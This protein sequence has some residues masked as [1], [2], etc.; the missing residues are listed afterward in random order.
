MK[1]KL[2]MLMIVLFALATE[3][4]A[5]VE[6]ITMELYDDLPVTTRIETAVNSLVKANVLEAKPVTSQNTILFYKGIK[7]LFSFVPVSKEKYKVDVPKDVTW[8][9]N[10][11]YTVNLQ[12][13]RVAFSVTINVKNFPDNNFRQYVIDN[14]D[15]TQDGILK[16]S[17]AEAVE[18]IDVRRKAVK[19][20]VGIRYFTNLL[21]LYCQN[22]FEVA[23]TDNNLTELDLSYNT[24]LTYLGCGQNWNLTKLNFANCKDLENLYC[25]NCKLTTLNV[26]GFTKLW[27]IYCVGNQ[28]ETLDVT[29]AE[30][31][32]TLECQNNR[33]TNLIVAK[34]EPDNTLL[35]IDCN[36]NQLTTVDVTNN[37][38][39]QYLCCYG[40]LIRG[41][42]METLV[43]SLPDRNSYDYQGDVQF[44]WI[45]NDQNSCTKQQ[46]AAAN[47]KNWKITNTQGIQYPGVEEEGTPRCATPT[48]SMVNGKLKF[49]C[50]TQGVTYNYTI[51]ES[52]V[53][54]GNTSEVSLP[55]TT[56]FTVYVYATKEGYEKS[57][58]AFKDIVLSVGMKG[59][60]DDNGDVDATDLT[61]LI[62]L[63]LKR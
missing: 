31:L 52:N 12:T 21:K 29:N 41:T 2:C 3:T 45:D 17:E 28:L 15:T 39:L 36:S 25:S 42:G 7:L 20:L 56:I 37:N 18:E 57:E 43:N 58:T 1:Q 62:D 32:S 61:R 46:V 5:A 60:M 13:L 26:S 50:Q 4:R 33:L 11:D 38:A 6:S 63:L 59:D 54:S 35:L 47:A 30:A 34:D 48:I 22:G 44:I 19:S 53:L 8:K 14:F 23:D 24:K 16:K 10:F 55:N 27:R 49:S 40:N 51:S 9:D